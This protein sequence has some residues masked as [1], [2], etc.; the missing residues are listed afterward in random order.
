MIPQWP[1]ASPN[2]VGVGG[3]TLTTGAYG[4][5][6]LRERL[7]QRQPAV[8]ACTGPAEVSASMKANPPISRAW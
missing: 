6:H 2:V 3:T 5:L 4:D 1:A 7:G 8:S